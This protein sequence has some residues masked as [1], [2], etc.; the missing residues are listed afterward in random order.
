[1]AFIAALRA[2]RRQRNNLP[3]AAILPEKLIHTTGRVIPGAFAG[4]MG[5]QR[6][7]WLIEV[8]PF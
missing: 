5:R 8:S 1:L 2:K 6:E 7:P 4:L 3:P